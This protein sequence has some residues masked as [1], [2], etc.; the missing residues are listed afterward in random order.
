MMRLCRSW[1]RCSTRFVLLMPETRVTRGAIR[2]Q[3]QPPPPWQC[4]GQ[5]LQRVKNLLGRGV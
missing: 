1:A 4:D 3:H 2:P 5:R